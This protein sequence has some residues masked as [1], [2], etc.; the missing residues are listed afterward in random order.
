MKRLITILTL[1]IALTTTAAVAKE[2]PAKDRSVVVLSKLRD[3]FYFKIDKVFLGGVVEVYN[4]KGV[5]IASNEL[6]ER[7]MLIDFFEVPA[8]QY[9]IKI[10]NDEQVKEFNYEKE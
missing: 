7:K 9:V 8:G 2:K 10:K 6:V 3:V 1:F 4:A 5:M